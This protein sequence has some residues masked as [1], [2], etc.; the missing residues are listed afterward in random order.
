M[1]VFFPFY[2]D[3]IL[4]TFHPCS[5][6][7]FLYSNIYLVS[8]IKTLSS[9]ECVYTPCI[10]ICQCVCYLAEGQ[11]VFI[12][13]LIFDLKV[14]QCFALGWS[15]AQRTQQLDVTRGQET[16]ATVELAMVPVVIHLASQNDDVTFGK[17]EIPWFFS[18]VGVEGFTARQ[19]W[20]IL[21]NIHIQCIQILTVKRKQ[22]LYRTRQNSKYVPF[23]MVVR[24]NMWFH[25][26]DSN[27]IVPDLK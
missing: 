19:C 15:L 27:L 17:L 25:S 7:V 1:T 9:G 23:I 11:T 6:S 24:K 18:F 13:V 8:D 16:M 4:S 5:L 21:K 12:L 10:C 22:F 14:V 26:A 20:Y 3:E 2:S